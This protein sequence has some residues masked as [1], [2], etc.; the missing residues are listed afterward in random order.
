M[1]NVWKSQKKSHSTLRAK[2]ATF[3]FWVL[4]WQKLVENAQIG[5]LK[6]DIWGDFQTLWRRSYRE[7][8]D[9]QKNKGGKNPFKNLNSR[10]AN[11]FRS[12]KKRDAGQEGWKIADLRV[13]IIW[14][15]RKCWK[16]IIRRT[17]SVSH[18]KSDRGQVKVTLIHLPL[19]L[20]HFLHWF[21][22]QG[23]DS[24]TIIDHHI[25][26]WVHY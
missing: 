21:W 6:W 13:S 1:H 12:R 9:I 26:G 19:I 3:T 4:N 25:G 23:N 10:A 14:R 16:A 24:T 17:K 20:G 8:R 7:K 15:N 22:W 5:K 11:D 18:A 2:R